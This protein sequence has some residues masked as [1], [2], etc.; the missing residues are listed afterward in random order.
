[1]IPRRDEGSRVRPR[2]SGAK[3]RN[4]D[5]VV[6]LLE[7]LGAGSS[8]GLFEVQ[9]KGDRKG[10]EEKRAGDEEK[11]DYYVNMGH[12]IRTLREDFP[13]IFHRELNFDIYRE[14][15]VFK[16]PI[17][18]IM[19]IDRYKSIFW[20]LRF[21]GRIFFRALWVDIVSVWQPVENVLVVRWTVH[22]V[23]RVPWESR[24]RFDG[25]SL[26]KF[27]KHG[28]IFEH[29]VDNVALNSPPK[30]KVPSLGELIEFLGCPSH[31]KPTYF[32]GSPSSSSSSPRK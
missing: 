29:R 23:P 11:G 3:V 19:G 30:F 32:D 13:A 28:K 12:G 2:F 21:H 8:Y 26:Y 1:M 31:A 22:G 25:T 14:D 20:G 7:E 17:N 18:T 5:V 4:V 9:V 10:D 15:I 24:G 16:D 27:D 6:G